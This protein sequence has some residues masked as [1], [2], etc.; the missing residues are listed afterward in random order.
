MELEEV[1]T[2]GEDDRIIQR[3]G[4]KVTRAVQSCHFKNCIVIVVILFKCLGDCGRDIARIPKR[5]HHRL[6]QGTHTRIFPRCQ[7]SPG[8]FVCLTTR[9]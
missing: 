6:P 4:A 2:P 8:E 7:Q 5:S 1:A 9:S 3:E